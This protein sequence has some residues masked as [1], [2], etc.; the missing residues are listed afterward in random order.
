MNDEGGNGPPPGRKADSMTVTR[1][2]RC[3]HGRYVG[4]ILW[5][6]I[7]CGSKHPEF[8]ELRC[9]LEAGHNGRHGAEDWHSRIDP[10]AVKF[11]A[12]GSFQRMSVWSYWDRL[13]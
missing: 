11:T 3:E 9:R 2:N 12:K 6:D 8:S 13:A 7:R 10:D 1:N 4:V 5:G